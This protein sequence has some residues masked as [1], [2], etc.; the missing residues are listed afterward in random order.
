LFNN[1]IL[2]STTQTDDSH[3]VPIKSISLS[4]INFIVNTFQDV[5]KITRG[6][7]N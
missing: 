5:G 4:L 6:L 7:S 1:L 2:D 3:A